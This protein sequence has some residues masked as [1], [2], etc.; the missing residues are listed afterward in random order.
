MCIA[1]RTTIVPPTGGIGTALIASC[2][3]ERHAHRDALAQSSL[4]GRRA[5]LCGVLA[6]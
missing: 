3:V 4:P 2:L 1:A 5:I 6:L